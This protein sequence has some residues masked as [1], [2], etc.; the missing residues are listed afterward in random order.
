M[1]LFTT[2]SLISL[3]IVKCHLRTADTA[4]KQTRKIPEN[5]FCLFVILIQL[6]MKPFKYEIHFYIS[7]LKLLHSLVCVIEFFANE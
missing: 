4:E 1:H 3:N 5:S 6:L 7:I 2:M